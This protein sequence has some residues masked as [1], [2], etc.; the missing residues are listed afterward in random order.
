MKI[1]IRFLQVLLGLL[2][3][4][5]LLIGSWALVQLAV[6]GRDAPRIWN[7]SLLTVETEDM[8]PALSPGDL[9]LIL[10]PGAV[11]PGDVVAFELGGKTTLRRIVGRVG[12]AWITKADR[13]DEADPAL[14]S[15]DAVLGTVTRS[16]PGAGKLTAFLWSVPGLLTVLVV[17]IVLLKLPGWL[18]RPGRP[19][20]S[21]R[22]EYSAPDYFQ[23]DW[24]DER[25]EQPAPEPE[26]E[27]RRARGKYTAR[28][29]R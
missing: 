26:P 28:H 22:A 9:A 10:D 24:Q 8:G 14:L 18:I 13:L 4:L 23:D 21:S 15:P 7:A 16:I 25:G 29:G 12:D 19:P 6:M 11:E 27:P 1:L 20:R 2:L 3:I 17:G 5:L